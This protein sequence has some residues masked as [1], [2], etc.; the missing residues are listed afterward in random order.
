M[1][2]L[3]ILLLTLNTVDD[4]FLSPP[5]PPDD[6]T[7]AS[8]SLMETTHTL[9]HHAFCSSSMVKLTSFICTGR[10][11]F[12][13]KFSTPFIW[14]LPL[15]QTCICV[16]KLVPFYP[17]AAFNLTGHF[18]VTFFPFYLLLKKHSLPYSLLIMIMA[19]VF[20]IWF[21]STSYLLKSLRNSYRAFQR[22]DISFG[23][24]N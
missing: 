15:P 3:Y 20:A 24:R 1:F 10:W 2:A 12:H 5:H 14:V 23:T 17:N 22:V 21:C 18:F 7:A 16:F 9:C 13:L 19:F 6:D 8:T 4:G 11:V